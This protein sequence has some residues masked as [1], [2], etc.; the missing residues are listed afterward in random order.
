MPLNREEFQALEDEHA[1][2][3]DRYQRLTAALAEQEFK[4]PTARVYAQIGLPR[5]LQVLT[6][7]IDT[8]FVK[9]PLSWAKIPDLDALIDARIAL[10]AFGNE[11][12]GSLGNLAWI[13]VQEAGITLSDDDSIP[14]AAVGL[15][16]KYRIVRTSLPDAVQHSLTRMNSWFRQSE[17]FWAS[18]ERGVPFAAPG[19]ASQFGMD[20]DVGLLW[21]RIITSRDERERTE[22]RRSLEQM[23]RETSPPWIE[24]SSETGPVTVHTQLIADFRAIETLSFDMLT[25]IAERSRPPEKHG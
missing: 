2:F 15:G 4:S 11:I 10:Q 7:C 18:L 13:W 21:S 19:H 22:A 1:T 9:L 16:P 12:R 14:E 5:R 24:Q 23:G 8:V 6:R 3:V 17:A 25:S 20:R